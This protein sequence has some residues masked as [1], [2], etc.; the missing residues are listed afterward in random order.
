MLPL[1]VDISLS[2]LRG[3]PGWRRG[4]SCSCSC[5]MAAWS[6]WLKSGWRQGERENGADWDDYSTVHVFITA[7]YMPQVNHLSTTLLW[8][9]VESC[10]S[11]A[12]SPPSASP[13]VQGKKEIAK[14]HRGRGPSCSFS[15]S[16]LLLPPQQATL[17]LSSTGLLEHHTLT[18]FILLLI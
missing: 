6:E 13:G 3:M 5:S 2:R 4:C 17:L 1:S 12:T 14:F 10:E 9:T 16:S 15:L 11:F 8:N 18:P 7:L